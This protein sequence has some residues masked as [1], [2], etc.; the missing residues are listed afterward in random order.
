MIHVDP[1]TM[2]NIEI[3]GYSWLEKMFTFSEHLRQRVFTMM[4][5]STWNVKIEQLIVC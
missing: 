2:K 1:L 3:V 5:S 4:F